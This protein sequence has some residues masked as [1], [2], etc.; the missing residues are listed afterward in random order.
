MEGLVEEAN[1]TISMTLQEGLVYLRELRDLLL[2]S[3]FSEAVGSVCQQLF[4]P[5]IDSHTYHNLELHMVKS[6][7][8]SSYV[9]PPL[10]SSLSHS[11]DRICLIKR[12]TAGLSTG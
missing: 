9:W 5:K 2:E 8:F 11:F 12:S 7:I 3:P 10:T 1:P 6:L 4:D